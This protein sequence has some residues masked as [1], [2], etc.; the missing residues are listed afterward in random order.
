MSAA[1]QELEVPQFVKLETND[2]VLHTVDIRLTQQM[3]VIADM[4]IME[5]DD[6]VIPLP[7][8]DAK[9]L[10]F[11]IKWCSSV[12]DLKD[13]IDIEG[14]GILKKLLS[15]EKGTE[16][17]FLLQIVM[18]SNYLNL[19]SL[20]QAGTEL[21]AAAIQSCNSTE[22]ICNLFTAKKD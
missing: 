21:I 19:D 3:G 11:I 8:V 4:P 10:M 16:Y 13:N 12:Q 15:T 22:E 14:E 7:R 18:A 9:T 5:G 6:D 2:G 20:L 17:S 1:S